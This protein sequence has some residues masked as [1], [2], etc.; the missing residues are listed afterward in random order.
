MLTY[1]VSS[2]GAKPIRFS[3]PQGATMEHA[4]GNDVPPWTVEYYVNQSATSLNVL[5]HGQMTV[6]RAG[7]AISVDDRFHAM[8][9]VPPLPSGNAPGD[10]GGGVPPTP[11]RSAPGTPWSVAADPAPAQATVGRASLSAGAVPAIAAADAVDA[12]HAVA[13]VPAPAPTPTPTPAPAPAP[14]PAPVVGPSNLLV[15]YAQQAQLQTQWCW[16]AVAS[17]VAGFYAPNVPPAPEFS[18][19]KLAC[20]VSGSDRCC[21]DGSIEV[22]NQPQLQSLALQHVQ[23]RHHSIDGRL[24]FAAIREEIDA[25]RPIAVTVLWPGGGGHAVV[26]TGYCTLQAR[27]HVQ[28]Q[29]PAGAVVAL[30]AL[31]DF[32]DGGSW[33]WTVT[34]RA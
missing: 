33:N 4:C 9:D 21:S 24:S 20:W 6:D 15:S 17:S 14:A 12:A 11:R 26:I 29:D 3:L 2:A 8:L 32:P 34:T 22:C 10:A 23:H 19:C 28:V 27:A 5:A 30:V 16:A 25:G 1:A 13:P 31:D 18:Q 7:T